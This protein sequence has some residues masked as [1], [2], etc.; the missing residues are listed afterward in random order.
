MVAMKQPT[1]KKKIEDDWR[2]NHSHVV[3]IFGDTTLG[4]GEL[5]FG[6]RQHQGIGLKPP[7]P[8]IRKQRRLVPNGERLSNME[9]LL[10]RSKAL[11]SWKVG[12][13]SGENQSP[14]WEVTVDP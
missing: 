7:E 14:A 3:D 1:S 11:F 10:E 6:Q 12:C 9:V 4:L 13:E 2:K 5:S 8:R